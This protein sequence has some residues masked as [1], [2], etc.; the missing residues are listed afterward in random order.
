M[1]VRGVVPADEFQHPLAHRIEGLEA[2]TR[3]AG[4]VFEG[5]KEGFGLG[6]VVGDTGAAEG[7]CDAQFVQGS[8]HGGA[9]H[10]ATIVRV[11][12]QW[13]QTA[14]LGQ[15]GFADDHRGVLGIFFFMDF[16]ADHLAR[17]QIK[18]NGKVS[19]GMLGVQIQGIQSGQARAMGLASNDGAL[20]NSVEP[21]VVESVRVVTLESSRRL[22][23]SGQ[24]LEV[25]VRKDN[26]QT[27]AIVQEGPIDAFRAGDL[28]NV[29]NDG[30]TVRVSRR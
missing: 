14:T 6:V 13:G 17:E 11:Q 30:S 5:T 7:R 29:T 27:V 1:A 16:P 15:T 12:H 20:V 2:L 23:A 28:V 8:Q 25:I 18:K 4:A 19:R 26:G 9:F 21:G 10:R 3:V 24:G 22:T